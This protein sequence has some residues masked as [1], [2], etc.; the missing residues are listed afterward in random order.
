MWWI[1][2]FFILFV[3]GIIIKYSIIWEAEPQVNKG[4]VQVKRH[5]YAVAYYTFSNGKQETRTFTLA[6][7]NHRKELLSDCVTVAAGTTNI[8]RL[9]IDF[10]D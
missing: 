10:H 8:L 2:I 6:N 4:A 5:K 7:D 1:L 9:T 3:V